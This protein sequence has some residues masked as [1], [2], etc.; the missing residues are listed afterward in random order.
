MLLSNITTKLYMQLFYKIIMRFGTKMLIGAGVL[1]VAMGSGEYTLYKKFEH[2]PNPIREVIRWPYNEVYTEL[3]TLFEQYT[4]LKEM[5]LTSITGRIKDLEGLQGYTTPGSSRYNRYPIIRDSINF[6]ELEDGTRFGYVGDFFA[7][8]GDKIRL[9]ILPS[10]QLMQIQKLLE[11]VKEFRAGHLQLLWMTNGYE[12]IL[13][14]RE[15]IR[16]SVQNIPKTK[17]T[18]LDGIV[19]D[20]EIIEDS[21]GKLSPQEK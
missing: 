16:K 1:G 12:D 10:Q 20:Y 11:R 4:A 5:Q 19:N 13:N 9:T 8:R 6:I 18:H 15:N 21:S 14:R 3:D 2:A 17:L 7:G